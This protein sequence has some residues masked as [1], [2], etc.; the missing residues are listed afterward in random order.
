MG[1]LLPTVI[2]LPSILRGR[3]YQLTPATP[4]SLH[5]LSLLATLTFSIIPKDKANNCKQMAI[6]I[7]VISRKTEQL[8]VSIT[9]CKRMGLTHNMNV[10]ITISA[11]RLAKVTNSDTS[12]KNY[13]PHI[14]TPGNIKTC[15]N[16]T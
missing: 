12:D 14:F 3:L 13:Q 10:L 6:S 15:I 1:D 11:R 7:S 9:K 2:A 4:M 5:G 8:M 16:I